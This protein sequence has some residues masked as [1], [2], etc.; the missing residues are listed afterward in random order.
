MPTYVYTCPTHT[1]LRTEVAHGMK[2][3]PVIECSVC[4]GVMHRVPQ[5]PLAIGYNAQ[6]ILFDWLD[7][8]YRRFRARK[9][10]KHAPDFS[11]NAVNKPF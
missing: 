2:E 10:G 8:R 4:G 6:D 7:E 5:V 3:D 9:A 1:E 11:P